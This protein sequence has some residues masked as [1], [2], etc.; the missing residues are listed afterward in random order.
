MIERAKERLPLIRP[1]LVPFAL[2]L[3]LLVVS[4]NWVEA[5]STSPW[6]YPVALL[7]LLPGIFL[8]MGILRA[9]RKLDD[10]AR[11]NLLEGMA[12]SFALTL[13]FTLSLGFLGFA[14][15]AQPNAAYITLF[16]A[17]TWLIGKLISA[18]RYQ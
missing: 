1:L 7:P 6:R 10:L 13:V 17:V 12:I 14:G 2:Y 18:R 11:K 8:A 5:L 4:I 15:L 3:V 16:M 9:I